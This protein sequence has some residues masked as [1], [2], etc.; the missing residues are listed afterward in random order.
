MTPCRLANRRQ[1]FGG[2]CCASVLKIEVASFS[3]I[4][5][6][7]DMAIRCYIQEY[8]KGKLML[9][10][11]APWRHSEW[12]GGGWGGGGGMTVLMEVSGQLHAPTALYSGRITRMS[13]K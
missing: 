4:W 10:L 6:P 3:E 9:R 7:F 2:M 1:I 11:Y 8:G 12:G 5:A 13:I